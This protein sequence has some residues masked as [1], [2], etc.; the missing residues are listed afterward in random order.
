MNTVHEAARTVPVIREVDVAVLGGGPSGMAAAVSAARHGAR[1]LLIERY[2]FLGGMGTAALV[3]NFC[4]LYATVDGKVERV[5][6]G[7]SEEFLS[8]LESFGGLNVPQSTPSGL[9]VQSYDTAAMKC[10]AD[11]VLVG[12]GVELMFHTLAVGAM[13][14]GGKVTALIVENKSGRG[15]I[16][17]SV[18]IDCSGDADLVAWAG[19]SFKKGNDDG[20]LAYPTMLFRMGGVDT[21]RAE[22]DGLPVLRQRAKEATERGQHTFMR[23]V[24]ITR[25][26]AHAGEWRANM[27]QVTLDG[28]PVDGTNADHLSRAEVI[29]RSQVV[30]ATRF[31]RDQ[32][33]GF[34]RSYLLDVAPQIGIRETRRLAG[35]YILD[36]QDVLGGATFDDGIGCSGWPVE[37]HLLGTVKWVHIH[38]DRGYHDLPYRML[39]PAELSNVLVAG[40]CASATQEAQAA[41]RVSGPCFVMGQAAGTAA[42]LCAKR[43]IGP[44]EVDAGELR[45]LL[46]TDGAFL[47]EDR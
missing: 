43:H 32:I 38:G 29:G 44:E 12:S 42:A 2:G 5:V 10:V 31:L 1:T 33:P 20:Y 19:L 45:A 35:N 17:A 16:R 25:P 3:T 4:G 37:Q 14:D 27:T 39:L 6:R 24:P 18:F 40:R 11:D 15:A 30:E 23:S 21:E 7:L 28:A 41:V 26:Q 22:R 47:G 13:V 36:V 8:R 34:E 46:K 9:V